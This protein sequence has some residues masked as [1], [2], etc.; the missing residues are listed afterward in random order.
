M[1]RTREDEHALNADD[2]KL[3]RHG[4]NRGK[5]TKLINE[6][7]EL[8]K[9]GIIDA[10]ISNKLQVKVKSLNE[11]KEYLS[12]LDEEI[13]QN[14]TLDEVDDDVDES[15]NIST[16]IIEY[17]VKF[18]DYLKGPKTTLR[19]SNVSPHTIPALEGLYPQSRAYT[20][21]RPTVSNELYQSPDAPSTSSNER[22]QGVRLP[23][24]SL[25]RFKGDVTKFQH[26]W[27]SFRCAVH[28]NQCPSDVH[29]LNYLVNSL[30]GQAYKA[31]EGLKIREEN[32]GMAIQLLKER[33][34]KT[35]HIISAHMQSLLTLQS[36]QNDKL[37]NIRSIYDTIMVYVRGLESLGFLLRNTAVY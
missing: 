8:M 25:P 17:I 24:I 23:K 4:S 18:N 21:P 14:C 9:E 29:K 36:F 33:F 16:Q 7:C 13:L 12:Q 19:S 28:E 35:Q 22:N 10:D 37:S 1:I 6:A 26:F 3:K 27:Q 15:T 11:K 20:P 31:L 32:Y 5:V 34:G 2:G 30:E